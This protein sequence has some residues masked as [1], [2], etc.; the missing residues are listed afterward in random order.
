MV[1]TGTIAKD[2][3]IWI[4]GSLESGGKI[5]YEFQMPSEGMTVKL[6]VSRGHV[7]LYSSFLLPNPNSALHDYKCEART[8][9]V[10]ICDEVF[11]PAIAGNHTVYTALGGISEDTNEYMLHTLIGDH[12]SPDD[13]FSSIHSK[14]GIVHV[15]F[16]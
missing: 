9:D 16:Y 6:C 3:G 4:R 12:T 2:V 14:Y 8:V 7:D 10:T 15:H 11:I 13:M 5:R 1:F